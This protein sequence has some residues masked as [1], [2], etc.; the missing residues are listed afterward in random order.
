M[1]LASSS[2]LRTRCRTFV[3][4]TTCLSCRAS[5]ALLGTSC[6]VSSLSPIEPFPQ[7]HREFHG[8]RS[9]SL[10]DQTPPLH[11][12]L[13]PI[14][15]HQPKTN[16]NF[17]SIGTRATEFLHTK[18]TEIQAGG[19]R[20][21]HR[22]RQQRRSDPIAEPLLRFHPLRY[23]FIHNQTRNNCGDRSVSGTNRQGRDNSLYSR[24]LSIQ[25]P[26]R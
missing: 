4:T 5:S 3:P 2:R 9:P 19:I 16:Y 26:A 21:K 20:S 6:L 1:S 17:S 25:E 18:V 24:I 15:A 11:T 13:L 8:N 14:P 7:T 22:N 23:P 10:L 12:L